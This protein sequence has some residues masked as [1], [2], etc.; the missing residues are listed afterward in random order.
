MD[1]FADYT[2][3]LVSLVRHYVPAEAIPPAFMT[4]VIALMFGI[5]LCVLGAKLSR[6]FL[7]LTL[8]VGGL[9]AGMSLGHGLGLS[10]PMFALFGALLA[11]GAGYRFYRIL[12]GL[13][14]G[15]FLATTAFSVLSAQTIV[16]RLVEFD[17][18]ERAPI[19]V[20]E[21]FHP[22]PDFG[23]SQV[24]SASWD[25]LDEYA[26]QFWSYLIEREPNVEKYAVGCVF[27]AGLL[28]VLMGVF[29]SRLTLILF[30]AAFGTSLIG[31][32]LLLL[33]SHLGMDLYE[34]SQ[35]RPEMSLAALGSFFIVSIVLQTMLTRPEPA[36]APAP[37]KAK[38]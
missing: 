4:A 10:A 14:T 20:V 7:A 28:G 27:A 13:F 6:W 22:G 37:A 11:G 5:V 38:A 23:Q 31:T 30:T 3:Q 25:R 32:G 2:E 21:D 17:R 9:I 1:K 33:G 36:P 15:M 16:P 24:A 26:Q 35:N 34:T 8:A 18:T 12:V 29:L 19:V